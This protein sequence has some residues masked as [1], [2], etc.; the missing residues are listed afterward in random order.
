MIDTG[1]FDAVPPE[2][3]DQMKSQF[4]SI[5]PLSRIGQAREVATTVLFLAFADSSFITASSCS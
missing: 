2:V 1:I 3:R 4:M 5:I